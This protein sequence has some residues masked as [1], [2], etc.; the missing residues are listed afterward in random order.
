MMDMVLDFGKIIIA[1]LIL[2]GDNA[3]I[4]GMAAAGLAPELRKKAILYGMII[5]AVLR[6]VFAVAATK[7]LGIPGILFV[8]SL[9]L[10][11]V[12][13]RL[14]QEIREGMDAQAEQSL[15][16]A[17]NPDAGYTG[18]PRRTLFAALIS[19]T[20]ADVSMSLDNVLAVAAIA[21]GNTEMLVFGLGL[22]IVLMAFAATLIMH[23]LTKFPWISWLGLIVLVYVAAEMMYRGFFDAST[24]LGPMLGLI[25]GWSLSKGH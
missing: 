20:I 14:Y 1:D 16:D 8:G 5:A 21:D 13:W 23:L 17:N 7:L 9:L 25:D 6:I 11:W 2:S 12:C 24:G 18:A 15:L 4:I 22:A 19:I 3:L 10:F